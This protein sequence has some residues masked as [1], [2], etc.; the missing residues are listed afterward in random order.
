[1]DDAQPGRFGGRRCSDAGEKR[2]NLAGQVDLD[3]HQ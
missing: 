3:C 1:M 2:V